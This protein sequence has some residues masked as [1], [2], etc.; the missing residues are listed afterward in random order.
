ML[1]EKFRVLSEG[2]LA[3]PQKEHLLDLLW[4]MDQVPDIGEIME[5]TRP[6]RRSKRS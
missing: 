6:I 5:L 3:N 4:N 1:N 2:I